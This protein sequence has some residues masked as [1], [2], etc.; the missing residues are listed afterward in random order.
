[1]VVL[2][3]SSYKLVKNKEPTSGLEQLSCSLRVIHQALQVCAGDCKCRIF[4]G[5][6]FPC[7]ALC[8]TVVRSR[9]YQSGIIPLRIEY[10]LVPHLSI[11]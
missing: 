8:C 7:L 2:W 1:M 4:R 3:H 6:S 10:P 11:I 9:W 5:V